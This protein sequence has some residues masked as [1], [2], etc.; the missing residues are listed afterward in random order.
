M[1]QKIKIR[2]FINENLK[3]GT[4]ITLNEAQSHYLSD[5]MKATINSQIKCFNNKQGEFIAKI[6]AKQK[7]QIILQIEQKSRDF[8]L[9]PDLWLLFSPL[10]KDNTDFVIQKATELGVRKIIP[11][12]TKNTITGKIKKERFEA[13]SIEAAE[14]SHRVDIPEIDDIITL[15][16]VLKNWDPARK[17]Y[18]LDETLTE[19]NLQQSLQIN[20]QKAAIICGPEGGFDASEIEKL[21]SKNYVLPISLGPRI[22]RAETAAIAA[23]SC[24]QALCGDWKSGEK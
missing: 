12:I 17:L 20:H 8:Y 5:V 16:E 6:C 11:I 2:L 3:E 18:F 23:I 7:K 10:K 22:L 21:R 24:W 15:E 19:N 13:Q 1:A 14:Q 9:P 4:Q